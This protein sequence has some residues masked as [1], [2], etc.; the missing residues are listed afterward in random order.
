[1]K[2]ARSGAIAVCVV[3]LACM[4]TPQVGHARSVAR[5]HAA[6]VTAGQAE[7][8]FTGWLNQHFR[9]R[10]HT[11]RTCPDYYPTGPVICHAEFKQGRFWYEASLDV[12]RVGGRLVVTYPSFRRWLRRWS[13]YS[14]RILRGVGE[15]PGVAS[16]NSPDFDWAWLAAQLYQS[17]QRHEQ[18]FSGN[19]YDGD[20]RGLGMF[21]IFHCQAASDHVICA[22][23]LGDAIYWLPYG[24]P[25]SNKPASGWTPHQIEEAYGIG[26]FARTAGRGSTVAIVDAFK[27]TQ[28]DHDLA[29]Y[30]H[31]YRLPPCQIVDGCL[32]ILNQFG[33]R[34]PLPRASAADHWEYFHGSFRASWATEQSLDIDML[35]AACPLC[36]IVVI[37]ANSASAADLLRAEDAA[38]AIPQVKAVSNS[39]VEPEFSGEQHEASH[40]SHP[41]VAYVASA[42]DS[43]HGAQFPA[44][45]SSVIAVGGTELAL[46]NGTYSEKVWN[47]ATGATG[48][49]CAHFV[50]APKW[51]TPAA[52]SL[53][54]PCPGQR[55]EN[56]IAAVADDLSVYDTADRYLPLPGLGLGWIPP[57]GGTSASAP[58]IAGMIGLGADG[59]AP[60]TPAALYA[61]PSSDFHDVTS[62]SNGDCY[63]MCTAG[64]GYDGPTGLGTPNGIAAFRT[65]P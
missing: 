1:M 44:A 19:D 45:L 14:A 21:D 40:F 37:Q 26:D 9:H 63:F 38:A 12:S 30:R 52:E 62:G 36:K 65:T 25:P 56:D 47:D 35:S 17:W 42:G 34:S 46:N 16:V 49:G 33:K 55:M 11:Y 3:M 4:A 43:G 53:G 10:I 23:K 59:G 18:S 24:V 31:R 2:G 41:D 27:D 57:V 8:V 6:H 28:L 51:Q 50:P 22:N 58:L 7:R 64:P 39:W 54:D 48:G 32:T 29:V 5:A 61:A 20:S 15:I 13:S 60:I